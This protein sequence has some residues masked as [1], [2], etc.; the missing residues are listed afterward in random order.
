M[1]AAALEN[2][3]ARNV[4]GE[5]AAQVEDLFKADADTVYTTTASEFCQSDVAHSTQDLMYHVHMHKSYAFP[6]AKKRIGSRRA[7]ERAQVTSLSRQSAE[8]Y[9]RTNGP[10]PR[11]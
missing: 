5:I 8:S 9:A 3:A 6:L 1:S 11:Q 2:I 10:K 4:R 7:R